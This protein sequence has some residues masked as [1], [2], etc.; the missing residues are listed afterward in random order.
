MRKKMMIMILLFFVFNMVQVT[1]QADVE[2]YGIQLGVFKNEGISDIFIK[3]LGQKGIDAYKIST[4]IHSVF[5]GIYPSK[6]EALQD[7]NIARQ[8]EKGAYVVKLTSR[9]QAVYLTQMRS[10]Q[11]TVSQTQEEPP[12]MPEIPETS[13]AGVLEEKKQI[14]INKTPEDNLEYTYRLVNDIE[15]RGIKGESKWFFDVVKGMEV[16]DFK[17]NLFS[18]VNELIRRDISYFTVYM[19]D[20]PIKSMRVKNEKDELLNNWEIDIPID[21]IKEGYNELKVKAYSRITDDP[22]ED[23]KNIANWVIIDGNTNYVITYKRMVPSNNISEFPRHFVGMYAD[24]ARGIGVVIP[25]DYTDK[26]ISA[27]LTLIAHMKSYSFGYI[28]PSTL[29]TTSD[30]S[31]PNFDSL[32]YVGNYKSVP[33]GLKT[34]I[35][36]EANL[37]YDNANIYKSTL[38]NGQRPV[39]MIVSDN[40]DRLIEAVKTLKNSDLKAQMVG[41][42][43]MLEPDLDTAIKVQRMDDYIYLKD[44]GINGIEVKGSNQQV[45]NIGLRIPSNEVLANESNINLKLRYSDNLDFEKSIVSVYVNGIPIGS[46]KLDRDKRDLDSMTFYIPDALR[47]NYYYDVRIVFELIPS[48]IIDCERYLAS[49]P[50]AYINGDSG[51][52]FPRQERRLM[53]LDNLPF[54]FSRN[55]DVDT[56]TIVIPDNPTREDFRIA[57]KFAELTGIGV[58]NNVGI[59]DVIKGTML[60]EKNYE[61]N[62]IIFG[63]PGE[64]SAIK[65]INKDLW[66][67]YNSQFSAVMSNEKIELLPETS[68]TATFFEL[69]NSS[70]NDQKGL[71]T[72][73][74]LDKESIIKAIDFLEDNKRGILSGDAAI[75][76]RD[77]DLLTF[78]FQKDEDERPIINTTQYSTQSMRDY[79]IFSGLLLLFLI[80]SLGFYIYKNRKKKR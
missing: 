34:I 70:Y 31:I 41:S 23:D 10:T 26:E 65:S 32:I 77:G 16:K 52:F 7:V 12:N 74:S 35:K 75:I 71:L 6:N 24:E 3:Q 13:I 57:G 30:Q 59:I 38:E 11:E 55:D 79:F 33:E 25:D 61:N 69:K 39:F 43:I 63:T 80:I 4:S 76:S 62:L 68:T 5:Y 28:V 42:Y 27:A 66:F 47:R 14:T 60:N 20:L 36:D 19:N 40:G 1:G 8:H 67:Q 72:I 64:N 58:K 48:G 56:T 37:Y 73:T 51:Y 22:C 45:A 9:Q 15:L 54:P 2:L 49:V 18:R 46:Q 50:W 44:L 29:V 78:R 17:F 21:V 53:L